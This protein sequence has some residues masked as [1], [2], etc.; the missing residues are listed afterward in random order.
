MVAVCGAIV[1][2]FSLNPGAKGGRCCL[3]S[4]DAPSAPA[5]CDSLYHQEAASMQRRE[6][7]GG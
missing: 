1:I 2:C 6:I 5:T 3:M 4:H 7:A